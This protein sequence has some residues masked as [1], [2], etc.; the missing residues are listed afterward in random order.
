MGQDT[1]QEK[2]VMRLDASIQSQAQLRQLG[3]PPSPCQLGERFGILGARDQ[4][5]KHLSSTLAQHI[6]RYRSQLDVGS[7]EHLLEPIDPLRARS[8]ISVLR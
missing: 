6:G 4:G 7:L 3:A 2:P 5:V 8:W 1:S